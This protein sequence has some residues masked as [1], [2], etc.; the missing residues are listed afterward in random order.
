M[1]R[2]VNFLNVDLIACTIYLT[3]FIVGIVVGIVWCAVVR[4][5]LE[6]KQIVNVTI[7]NVNHLKKNIFLWRVAEF[8]KCTDTLSSSKYEKYFNEEFS[9]CTFI[10]CGEECILKGKELEKWKSN[11]KNIKNEYLIDDENSG[12]HTAITDYIFWKYI[13]IDEKRKERLLYYQSYDSY[14]Y[15]ILKGD[16]VFEAKPIELE[17]KI[18]TMI[19]KNRR[20]KKF[21]LR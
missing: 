16:T 10:N 4:P 8:A 7:S 11:P 21:P 19:Y 1:K 15:F 20:L 18:D 9:I 3:V 17:F 12:F 13:T 6:N 5:Y 14:K 2:R